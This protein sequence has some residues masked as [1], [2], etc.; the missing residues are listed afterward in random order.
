MLLDQPG[1]IRAY[2]LVTE[3]GEGPY[4]GGIIYQIGKGYKVDG[5][6]T[7]VN[8][9]CGPGINL[10]TLDWCMKEWRTGYRILIS[11][12]TAKDIAAIP[13]ATDGKFRVRRCKIVGE[14]DLIEIGLIEGK[15]V[16]PSMCDDV[17][18]PVEE[19]QSEDVETQTEA[20]Q[21]EAAAED[22]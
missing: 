21:P 12:F 20:E 7:N 16:V 19:T 10:A 13:T 2:K 8:L 6:D 9:H 3:N 14:K 4:N 18:A 22:E 11:E 5:A 1:K 17:K 15:E